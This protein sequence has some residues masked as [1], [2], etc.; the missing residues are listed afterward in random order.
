[1]VSKVQKK[2]KLLQEKSHPAIV[3]PSFFILSAG[4]LMIWSKDLP[5]QKSYILFSFG[6]LDSPIIFTLWK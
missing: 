4:M 2:K 6:K 1:M 5:F 3:L